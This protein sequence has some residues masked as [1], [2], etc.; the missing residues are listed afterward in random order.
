MTGDPARPGAALPPPA[1][2]GHRVAFIA[3]GVGVLLLVIAG[4]LAVFRYLPALNEARALRTDLETMVGRVQDAGL[5]IDRATVDALDADL[6]SARGRLDGLQGL[7]AGDPLIRIARAFPLTAANVRGADDVVAGAGDLLDA[8]GQGLAIGR[9]FVEI[10]EAQ[11]AD[12]GTA[13]A[14]SQLVELMATSRDR[15]VA[16]AASVASA[17]QT[18]A[19]V[20]DGL[21]GQVE[22]VRDAMQTRI[23]KY[24]PLLDTYLQVSARLPAILGWD[25]PRRY[26][27][28]TQDPAE[29]R[30]SGG[31]IGS[32][33]IIA[34]DKGRITERRFQDVVTLDY[35]NNYPFVRPPQEL[36]DYLLGPTQSWQLADAGWSPDFPTS[37][38]DALRLYTNE[39][40][41]ARIDGV[42]GMTTYTIDELLKVIGPLTVPGYNV[43]IA[44]GETTRKVLQQ[45]RATSTPGG[46]RKAFLSA[47]ADRLLTS[48]LALPPRQWGDLLGAADT[49]G[50]SHLLLAWFRDGAD[51]ALVA[52]SGFDG[53]VRQDSG[54]YLYP[55]DSNVAPATKLNLLTT[56]TLDLAVQID[57]V[58]NARNTLAVTWA[59]RVDT[60]DGAPY[61]AM[62]NV[63][64]SILGMYFRLLVPER[65]RIEAVSGG[66][67]APV[68]DPAVVEDEA[69]RMA[70]GTYLQ[71]PPGQTSL[72]Y[73]WTS[74]YAASVD[75]SGGSYRLTIQA[76]PGMLPGPLTLTIRVPDGYRITAASPV[77]TVN[78]ATAAMATTFDRNIVAGV[79]FGRWTP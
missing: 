19:A 41:D 68:T 53:A 14:L 21:I 59:N 4:A 2:R 3:V 63:G 34:F 9:Q 15:A 72:A 75:A 36:A 56:R 10:R 62:T 24:G 58:G 18:L 52:Q 73:T 22:S 67:L 6:A 60:P 55:V 61:R 1:H 23:E 51:Q 40:G 38:Q 27:V 35:T 70:I 64:G 33:G 48:L 77:L 65:S 79:E 43:T 30:P 7:L 8:V 29:L 78:G 12:P 5:G 37:A 76:Q 20:P 42:L 69:G 11:A 66:R 17:Q 57:A 13:S 39:S 31:F 74:P 25:G 49:F 47:F 71:V 26:L 50:K 46:D 54:D 44:S 16:A 45:T 32:Y 28:L